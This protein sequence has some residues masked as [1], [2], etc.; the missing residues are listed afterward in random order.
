MTANEPDPKREMIEQVPDRGILIIVSLYAA[1]FVVFGFL[2][3]T[4]AAIARGL[5]AIVT[6]R[7]TLLT[8]YFGK[9]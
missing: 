1:A 5:V 9:T 3:D 8:D 4:P 7:D 2:V 6:S